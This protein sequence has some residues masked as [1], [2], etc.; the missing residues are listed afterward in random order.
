MAVYIRQHGDDKNNGSNAEEAVRS[1][2]QA[3][4]IAL[5]NQDWEINIDVFDFDRICRELDQ[6]RATAGVVIST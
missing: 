3:A 6:S 1:P 2:H 4:R 5:G